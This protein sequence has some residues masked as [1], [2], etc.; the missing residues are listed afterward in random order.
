MA[1]YQS[2][3]GEFARRGFDDA[4]ASARVWGRWAERFGGE[5][6]VSLTLFER[7]ADRDQALDYVYLYSVLELAQGTRWKQ[8]RHVPG[9]VA[10]RLKEVARLSF[11]VMPE[12][13]CYDAEYSIY[14]HLTN[15][16]DPKAQVKMIGED[17]AE[18]YL[19]LV[20]GRLEARSAALV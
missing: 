8:S 2:Q 6:P 15:G 5:P 1:R 3:T 14:Y 10:R 11:A 20:A 12:A 16:Y 7:V 18:H 19:R 4:T 9:Y 13:A 17:I